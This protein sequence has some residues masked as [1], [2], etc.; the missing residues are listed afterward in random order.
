MLA[1][2]PASAMTPEQLFEDGNRLFRDDLYWA[3]LLRYRQ[4]NEAGMD[5]ALLHYNTGIA[6]YK[7]GQYDR[8]RE[9]F[10]KATRSPALEVL[11]NY[12]LGLTAYAA[13]DTGDA[14]RWFMLARDQQQNEKIAELAGRAIARIRSAQMAEDPVVQHAEKAARE[15]KIFDLD[16][17]G[18]IGFGTD[19]NIFRSPSEPYVDF[20]DP[21]LPVVTPEVVSGAYMPVD[22]GLRYMINSYPFEGFYGAYRLQ[23]D[24]YQDKEL[25][26]A[27]R[28][29]HEISFGNEYER[30]EGT[31]H[32]QVYSAFRISRHDETYYDP[33]DGL[34]RSAGGVDI[35]ER[36][37]Y[38]RYGPDLRLRQTWRRFGIGALIKGYLYDYEQVETVPS[39]DN[40]YFLFGLHTQYEFTRTSLL[41]LDLEK[42][43][44]RYTERPSYDLDGNQFI[45]NATVRYDYLSA[46]LVARQRIT[47]NMWF[48][49]GYE[50]TNRED[51][52]EGYNNYIRDH[53]QFEFS[54]SPGR[55]FDFE[56]R[57]FYRNYKYE[58]AY[59]FN[60]PTLP[61]KTLETGRLNVLATY[62][63]TPRLSLVVD[64][65][66]D[67]VVSNDTRI[68]YD[69]ARYTIGVSWAQ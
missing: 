47:R 24:Y 2:V 22:L 36:M 62:R 23:S 6:H 4:A 69:R 59:A 61:R 19:S 1:V 65:R 34:P 45:T 30:R 40:E 39:Y 3:A 38:L 35:S 18:R 54:W 44:R 10:G 41:R 15:R 37:N 50:R 9:S 46:K 49:F 42:S 14:L 12:N 32:R 5:T 68:Q 33:D 7:A 17:Y 27:N 57:A 63:M 21:T 67:D 31:R 13:G 8:A 48:G 16:L 11:T 26:N 51:R 58:N 43:S 53:Y 64:G 29:S 25:E 28:F 52:F 60:N 56:V 20:S 55:R 66:F